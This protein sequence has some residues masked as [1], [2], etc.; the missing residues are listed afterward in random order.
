MII[1]DQG[2]IFKTGTF[3]ELH[4]VDGLKIYQNSQENISITEDENHNYLESEKSLDFDEESNLYANNSLNLE[5]IRPLIY[6]K[7]KSMTDRLNTETIKISKKSKTNEAEQ[8]D[9]IGMS[10]GR[11]NV[12]SN[13]VTI[14]DWIKLFSFGYGNFWVIFTILLCILY[15]GLHMYLYYIIGQLSK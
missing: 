8:E 1:L 4:G 6:E 10:T 5:A 15:S 2:K 11:N 3:D 13:V 12:M 9:I 14:K 7:Q